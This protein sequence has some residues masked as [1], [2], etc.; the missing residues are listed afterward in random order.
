MAE[1]ITAAL[2]KTLRD[3]TD[4]P[5]MECK[6]ILVEA[7]GDLELAIKKIREAGL[8][9]AVKKAGRVAAE[10]VIVVGQKQGRALLIEVNCETDFVAREEKFQHFS[11]QLA[12]CVLKTGLDS[13][14]ALLESAL[15]GG[16]TVE[17]RRLELVS[18]IGENISVRRAAV[19]QTEGGVLGVYGHAGAN[20][21]RIAAMVEL[22]GGNE[23][24]AK[25]IAMHIAAMHPEYLDVKDIP[26]SRMNS[27]RAILTKQTEEEGKAA[28]KIPM[29]VEGKVKKWTK[30]ITLLGQSFVKD[31]S[32]TVEALLKQSGANVLRFIRFEVGE[33]IEKKADN[34]V[35][36]VMAQARGA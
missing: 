18:Q 31:P 15:E 22:M 19:F 32:L 28:D 27:E 34:F 6:R 35:E 12:D 33:G 3:R 14:P 30:E 29:I 26:A 13:V 7:G 36:E 2:V 17:A 5:M 24:L 11:R 20:G 25:D 9:K 16:S 21:V 1:V 8:V 23:A 4:A 10:G